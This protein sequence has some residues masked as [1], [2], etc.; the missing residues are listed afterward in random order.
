MPLSEKVRIEIFI[1]DPSDVAYRD[2]LK[3]LATELSY[4][5]GGCT[6]VPASG[7]YRS[8]DGA[9]FTDKINILF[10]DAPLL[11]ARD[12]LAIAQYVDWVRSAAQRALEREEVVLISVYAVC[13]GE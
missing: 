5:F 3:E 4:A 13:H 2:L 7:Q 8:L 1:P 12:R 11:W 6:Q 10:S 9:I